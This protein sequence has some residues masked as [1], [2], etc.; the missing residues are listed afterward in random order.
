MSLTVDALLRFLAANGLD[1]T[2]TVN[3]RAVPLDGAG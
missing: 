1:G 3:G 2:L